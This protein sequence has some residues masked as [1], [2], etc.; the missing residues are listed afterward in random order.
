MH[1]NT[2][3]L[4]S[5]HNTQKKRNKTNEKLFHFRVYA[6]KR[7]GKEIAENK[8]CFDVFLCSIF[9]VVIYA[10]KPENSHRALRFCVCEGFSASNQKTFDF[11]EDE[12]TNDFF[13]L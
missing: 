11:H 7:R 9:N 10:Q 3:E 5:E 6:K 8:S 2:A 1:N 12:N 13:S 4:W